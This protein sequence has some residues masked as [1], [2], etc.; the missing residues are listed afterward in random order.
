MNLS[1]LLLILSIGMSALGGLSDLL[2]TRVFGLSRQHYWSDATYIA[3]LAIAV[4]IL[5]KL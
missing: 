1:S 5:W 4:H 2:Q 3:V